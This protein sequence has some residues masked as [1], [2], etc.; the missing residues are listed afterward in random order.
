MD[1]PKQHLGH[2]YGP[3]PTNN[4]LGIS[5]QEKTS[6]PI[7]PD[8]H[9]VA[10][11]KNL[12][13][14]GYKGEELWSI[15]TALRGPDNQSEMAKDATTAIIRHTLGLKNGNIGLFISHKDNEYYAKLRTSVREYSGHHFHYHAK[16]AFKALNL[17]WDEV[18]N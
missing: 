3:A 1:F 4:Q 14:Y 9:I 16:K 6:T 17:K 8:D 12:L 10:A 11:V 13:A 18:N 15:L 2:S 7:E 5:V